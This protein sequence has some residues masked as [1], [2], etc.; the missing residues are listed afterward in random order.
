ML[1]AV[2]GQMADQIER[3]VG[4]S[5]PLAAGA[6]GVYSAVEVSWR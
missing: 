1:P 3:P 5:L 6:G 2:L 4:P